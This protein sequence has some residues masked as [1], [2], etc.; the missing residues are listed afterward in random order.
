MASVSKRANRPTKPWQARYRDPSGRQHSKLFARKI[1]A[2]RW[3]V[4]I[5]NS[6]MHGDYVDPSLGKRTFSEYADEWLAT[7]AGVG[8]RTRINVEGRI[9]NYAKPTFGMMPV[10]AV[11]PIHVRGLWVIS[12]R[13]DSRHRP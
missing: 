6:K 3:L 9:Q 13:R 7:K 2:E 1:D 12:F 4:S 11:R 5:E 10:S 8:A